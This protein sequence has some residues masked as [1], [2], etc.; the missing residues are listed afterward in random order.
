MTEDAFE[1]DV[2]ELLRVV[3]RMAACET[4]LR[5]LAD[6]LESRIR[7]LH[8]SWRG[9]AADA[10]DRAQAAWAEGFRDMREALRQMRVAA[11]TAHGNYT[12]AADTNLRMWE[13]VG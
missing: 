6:D 12:S 4:T 10:H 5:D 11:H 8:L 9:E 1:V 7:E 2:D 3:D 13:Q